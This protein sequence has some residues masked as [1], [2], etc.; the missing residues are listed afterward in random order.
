[1]KGMFSGIRWTAKF[2]STTSIV[3]S[4]ARGRPQFDNHSSVVK[5]HHV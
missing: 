5:W 3:A 4:S 1:M 2:S